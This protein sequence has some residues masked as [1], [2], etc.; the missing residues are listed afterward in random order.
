MRFKI[1]TFPFLICL[2]LATATG[3]EIWTVDHCMRYAVAHNHEVVQKNLELDSYRA[4]HTKAV[5][6]FL[7]SASASVGA[8]YNFG[9]AIDPETNVY[10]N[11]NTFYNSYSLEASLPV[12]DGLYRANQLRM[13]KANRLMGKHGAEA[14]RDDVA[15]QVFQAFIDVLYYQGTLRMASEKLTES[16]LMLRQTQVMEEVGQ[17]SLAD[18]AQ[19]EATAAGDEW[20]VTRQENLLLTAEITL[21]Q[22]M[23]FP[24]DDSLT[25]DTTI[26]DNQSFVEESP[27]DVCSIA[28]SVN[29]S[30]QQAEA[31]AEAAR[32]QLRMARSDLMPSLYVGAGVST[33]YYRTLGQTGAASFHNQ[34][35]N[36]AGEYVYASLS[37]PLF[38]RLSALSELRRQRNNLR[39]AVDQH[40]QKRSELQ[41]FVYQAVADHRGALRET[42]KMR[43]KVE[44]DSLAAY[45][46]WRKFEEGQSSAID[47]HTQRATLLESR[48]SLLQCR[49]TAVLKEKMI[50]YYKGIPL[51]NY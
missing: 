19:M 42:E 38:N 18:V 12:F 34:F 31:N 49:L 21:K 29:P 37:I 48:A 10:T 7:P 32:F 13:A 6:A 39:I 28:V 33:T 51:I 44:A 43:R 26:V 20:E 30:L 1:M 3:G 24:L 27:S 36:N 40:E 17:K 15:M 45:V 9:R 25:L 46:T 2:P 5:G 23:N 11:V 47:V 35:K 16:R 50:S 41:K 22:L 4:L 8:Q 14:A